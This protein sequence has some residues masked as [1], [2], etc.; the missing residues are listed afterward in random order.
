MPKTL[1]AVS[2]KKGQVGNE[3]VR[4]AGGYADRFEF[5]FTDSQELDISNEDALAAFFAQY[6]PAYY[7]NCAAYTAVDKAETD[8][9]T[10]RKVNGHAVGL[11]AA[12]C[13]QYGTTLITISTDYVF[14]GKAD[15]PYQP[16]DKTDPVNYYG[17]TKLE[18]EQLALQNNAHTLVIRTSWVYSDHGQN[19]VKT[20]LRL[21]K[22]REEISVVN[23]QLGAP[24]YAADLAKTIMQIVEA[25]QVGAV[26]Y[27]IY[28]YSNKGLIS[29]YD[30][31]SAIR[32]LAGLSCAIHPVPTTSF[33][34][35]AKRPA[36]SAMDTTAIE[37]DFS[38]VIPHW[39][40]SLQACLGKLL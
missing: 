8:K 6:K 36:Y 40:E 33:P 31:A 19:F 15:R 5:I 17:H 32:D 10:A 23:D 12:Q 3:L 13:N 29:W 18:G 11:I 35:P 24:T 30:F 22:E 26:H 20:M 39:K 2:G 4:L 1:I 9:D 7:I 27:G 34:T 21:M 37:R 38:L 14:N 28:H 16:Q 25:Y